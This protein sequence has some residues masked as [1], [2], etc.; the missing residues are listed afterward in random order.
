MEAVSLLGKRWHQAPLYWSEQVK[1]A[2]LLQL[3]GIREERELR[4]FLAPSLQNMPDP[5]LLKDM[6]QAVNRICYALQQQET[7]LIYGDY[8]V[9]GTCATAALSLFLQALG[10]QV[11]T[12]IPHRQQ[13]GY[14]LQVGVIDTLARQAKLLI[15][16][17]CGSTSHEAIAL[18]KQ[19]G[20][21]TIVL[22]HH[23]LDSTP[24][25]AVA[26]VN[27]HQQACLFPDKN[28]CATAVVFLLMVA[29]RSTLRSQGFFRN[30]AEPDVRDALDLVALATVADMMPLVGLNR[31]FVHA[32]LVRMRAGRT[33]R[34]I[35]A[36]AEVAKCTLSQL[37]ATDIGFRLAPRINAHGRMDSAQAA[38]VLLQAQGT[39]QAMAAARQLDEA[40]QLRKQVEQQVLKAA[41]A[42]V[43]SQNLQQQA[44]IVVGDEQWHPGVLGLVAGRL[45]NLFQRPAIVIGQG[46]KGSGRSIGGVDLHHCLSACQANLLR[47]GGHKAA[48]GLTLKPEHLHDL[49]A[50]LH[51]R[52]LQERGEP[53]Y[54]SSLRP[55][56][57]IAV[58]LLALTTV[59]QLQPLGP[60]GQGNGEP[61]LHI[62]QLQVH[63]PQ[64]VGE[65]HLK[66]QL[67]PRQTAAIGFGMAALLPKLPA[68]V[69]ILTHVERC[70]FYRQPRLQLR[71][72]DMRVSQSKA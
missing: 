54:S 23:Q 40:N 8:D 6:E 53:P 72:L 48:V 43:A 26:C 52:L 45:A 46:G 28:I 61:L 30:Q 35:L 57:Q 64:I 58:E 55:D 14:G 68:Y 44:A 51:Q 69:D 42:Q 50:T 41:Q 38:L 12:Y 4:Q 1:L 21:E 59:E 19:Q 3:R 56:I 67:G 47:F 5:M 32:G 60:F 17:D 11:T 70:T 20:L 7:I 16:V 10:G 22:D 65:Q 18:A 9:D 71:L 25:P 62:Q 36:L 37:S 39:E 49:R 63:Q 29:L 15:T 31:I 33:R 66:L 24:P 13:E 27:P 34:G 2:D